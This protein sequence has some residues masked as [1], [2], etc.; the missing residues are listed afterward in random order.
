[1]QRNLPKPLSKPLMALGTR[2]PLGSAIKSR[3]YSASAVDAFLAVDHPVDLADRNVYPK[4]CR[5]DL[6]LCRPAPLIKIFLKNGRGSHLSR[7]K[8][9]ALETTHV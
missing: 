9:S 3:V 4:I 5:A 7:T 2:A 6:S 1:M 8:F